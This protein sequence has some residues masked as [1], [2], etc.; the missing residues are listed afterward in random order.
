MICVLLLIGVGQAGVPA[1]AMIVRRRVA[2]ARR[3]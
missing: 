3:Q 1:V 2:V